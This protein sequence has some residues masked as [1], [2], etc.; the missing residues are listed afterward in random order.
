MKNRETL[1]TMIISCALSILTYFAILFG[2]N[3]DN[4]LGFVE[5]LLVAILTLAGAMIVQVATRCAREY[6]ADRI[7]AYAAV[8][9]GSAQSTASRNRVSTQQ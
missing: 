1:I 8:R 2:G 6:E 9:C 4:P 5:A 7:S 3:R